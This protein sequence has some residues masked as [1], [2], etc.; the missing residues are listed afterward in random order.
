MRIWDLD[1]KLLCRSHLL[2]EHRE[3][4]AIWV[5]ITQE[6]KGYKSHPEVLRWRDKLKALYNRHELI[7]R[8]M[9]RRGYNHKSLLNNELAKGKTKQDYYLDTIKKQKEILRKKNCLCFN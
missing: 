2:G 8:E 9:G 3:I 4:H 7:V 1:P 6:K 5:I